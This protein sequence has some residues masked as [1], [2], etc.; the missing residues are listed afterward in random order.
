MV[1][2]I[3]STH[4]VGGRLLRRRRLRKKRAKFLNELRHNWPIKSLRHRPFVVTVETV[5]DHAD[6]S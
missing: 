4:P 6:D 5:H 3:F 2:K 1:R